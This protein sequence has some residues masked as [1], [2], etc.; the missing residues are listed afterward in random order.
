MRTNWIVPTLLAF[1][2]APALANGQSKPAKPTKP[3]APQG[4]PD[5][6]PADPK[7]ADAKKAYAVGDMVDPA[8]AFVDLTGKTRKLDEFKGKTVVLDFWSINCPVSKG[9][10]MRLKKLFADFEKKNVV[11][12]AVDAN[13]D[14]V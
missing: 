10:E 6:K 4:K 11:F 5:A 14:E 3:P 2:I 9:Y 12:L 1:V 8:T 13:S 7:K